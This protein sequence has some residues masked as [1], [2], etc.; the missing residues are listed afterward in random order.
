LQAKAET[1][2]D[3]ACGIVIA[4][5]EAELAYRRRTI[6]LLEETVFGVHNETL[7]DADL[8]LKIP[9]LPSTDGF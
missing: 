9:P 8:E 2:D 4:H 1:K 3:H 5:T 6:K 7:M